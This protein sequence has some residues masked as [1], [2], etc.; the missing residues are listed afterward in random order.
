MP[1][2]EVMLTVVNSV[3]PFGKGNETKGSDVDVMHLID[4]KGAVY[5]KSFQ[6]PMTVLRQ[7]RPEQRR[8]AQH[9]RRNMMLS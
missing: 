8:R 1:A 4:N 7:A 9:E 3:G 6:D 2:V 5:K